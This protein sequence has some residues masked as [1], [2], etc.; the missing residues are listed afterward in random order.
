MAQAFLLKPSSAQFGRASLVPYAPSAGRAMVDPTPRKVGK[1]T[2]KVS[3]LAFGGGPL[4]DPRIGNA[5]ALETVTAAWE[6]G[7][8]YFDTA[9][10]YGVDRSE[11]RLGMAANPLPESGAEASKRLFAGVFEGFGGRSFANAGSF[12]AFLDHGPRQQ[13]EAQS[14]LSCTAGSCPG[15][16]SRGAEI[17][18][19]PYEIPADTGT[20]CPSQGD[21]AVTDEA[22]QG[23]PPGVLWRAEWEQAAGMAAGATRQDADAAEGAVP[24]GVL[25]QEECERASAV[26]ATSGANGGQ[27]VEDN[28]QGAAAV[29]IAV[30]EGSHGPTMSQTSLRHQDHLQGVAAT[31][32]AGTV[33]SQGPTEPEAAPLRLDSLQ[34]TIFAAAVGSSSAS[35]QGSQATAKSRAGVCAVGA[36]A[37]RR[38]AAPW[39][40]KVPQGRTE[41]GLGAPG[42]TES[43]GPSDAQAAQQQR[44]ARQAAAGAVGRPCGA[45]ARGGQVLGEPSANPWRRGAPQAPAA[46]AATA[47]HGAAGAEASQGFEPQPAHGQQ[48]SAAAAADLGSAARQ[49]DAWRAE[50]ASLMGLWR[51]AGSEGSEATTAAV[52][53]LQAAGT[54]SGRGPAK[55]PASAV[56]ADLWGAG[57]G[58]IPPPALSPVVAA[59]ADLQ[60]GDADSA[61]PSPTAGP[62]AVALAASLWQAGVAIFPALS[63]SPAAA[64]AAG[65]WGVGANG[66]LSPAAAT[67]ADLCGLG[68]VGTA[69]PPESVAVAAL[70]KPAAAAAPMA[71]AVADQWGVGA[72]G[73]QAAPAKSPVAAAASDGSMAAS[74]GPPAVGAAADLWGAG[75]DGLRDPRAAIADTAGSWGASLRQEAPKA[76]VAA[77]ATAASAGVESGSQTANESRRRPKGPRSPCRQGATLLPAAATTADLWGVGVEGSAVPGIR[78]GAPRQEDVPR[79]AEAAAPDVGSARTRCNQ[80]SDGFQ[81]APWRRSSGRV[82]RQARRL[83][84]VGAADSWTPSSM[85]Q[86]GKEPDRSPGASRQQGSSRGADAD[87]ADAWRAAGSAQGS[88]AP[89]EIAGG[90]KPQTLSDAL[91]QKELGSDAEAVTSWRSRSEAEL[92]SQPAE[93]VAEPEPEEPPWQATAEQAA[94]SST[95]RS[96]GAVAAVARESTP[97]VGSVK[98]KLREFFTAYCGRPLGPDGLSYLA[99]RH[100]GR[101]QA[102]LKLHCVEGRECDEFVGD[103]CDSPEEAQISVAQYALQAYAVESIPAAPLPAPVHAA[104]VQTG[105]AGGKRPAPSGPTYMPSSK[106]SQSA[107][108]ANRTLQPEGPGLLAEHLG[109]VVTVGRRWPWK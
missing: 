80:A 10:W 52:A 66:G 32:T 90:K 74:P 31:A 50:A 64:A 22:A 95:F 5:D 34:G 83:A 7:A 14:G 56:A 58:G 39:C 63:K 75:P 19:K 91:W 27:T 36:E 40:G 89:H 35:A 101:F 70:G 65:P 73:G 16:S 53:G 43:Q 71:A 84:D 57:A 23:A 21:G 59:A 77:A 12:K 11:R 44:T 69:L 102:T 26:V 109:V 88:R 99:V 67:T 9:P 28:L 48:A 13:P 92:R 93:D 4:G 68:A 30:I 106:R 104:D 85:V 1:S 108:M 86:A 94:S 81:G 105:A 98:E 49:L 76:V 79:A 41:A 60:G 24:L 54:P 96:S 97:V 2:L 8:R 82:A 33:S 47:G 51:S 72:H 6:S 20:E 62:P 87:T 37:H 29:A 3:P 45:G 78:E 25:W 100:K 38:P 18:H 107:R 61:P 46:A 103:L 42:A 55:P 17:Q 15:S